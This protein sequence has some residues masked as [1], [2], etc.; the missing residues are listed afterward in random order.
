MTIQRWS[1]FLATVAF[2]V[3]IPIAALEIWLDRALPNVAQWGGAIAIAIV[4]V[5][6]LRRRQVR[7]LYQQFQGR[8]AAA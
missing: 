2:A 5:G 3:S 4:A 7:R 1:L 6:F 8:E